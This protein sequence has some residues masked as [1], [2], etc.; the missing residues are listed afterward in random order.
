MSWG[1]ISQPFFVFL[2][3]DFNT[4]H[5]PASTRF[6]WYWSE[7]LV[8]DY[9]HLAFFSLTIDFTKTVISYF[10]CSK[11]DAVLIAEIFQWFSKNTHIGIIKPRSLSICP[12]RIPQSVHA[13]SATTRKCF[14]A[15]MCCLA[16]T[17]QPFLD[18]YSMLVLM[19]LTQGAQRQAPKSNQ[20]MV[21]S[22]ATEKKA[23]QPSTHSRNIIGHI[24]S[25]WCWD[26][27]QMVLIS[28]T[29]MCLA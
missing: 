9:S 18:R 26:N 1:H 10:H 23:H 16:R 12:S 24:S 8:G 6:Q 19:D 11:P 25:G 14:F 20:F 15:Q 28:H 21:K 2:Q 3:Y 29:S 5:Y 17:Y 7:C 4:I 13:V 22:I 27:D